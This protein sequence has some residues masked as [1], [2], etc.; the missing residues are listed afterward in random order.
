MNSNRAYITPRF[1]DL[2]DIIACPQNLLP[3]V[4]AENLRLDSIRL[5][6]S[7][8]V[9]SGSD[10]RV[11]R[12]C[13]RLLRRHVHHGEDAGSEL[14]AVLDDEAGGEHGGVEHELH[15]VLRHLAGPGPRLRL[16]CLDDGRVGVDLKHLAALHVLHGLVVAHG[17]RA[18]DALHV[19]APPELG[20]GQDARRV[21]QPVA[22]HHLLNLV[23][24]HL[25]HPVR[26]RLEIRLRGLRLLLFLLGVLAEIQL[27]LADVH[28]RLVVVGLQVGERDLVDGLHQ[29]QHL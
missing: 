2:V 16:Q 8:L 4:V 17:L 20:R 26:Q 18:H 1:E 10:G 27:V 28:Q 29:V 11:R 9:F 14:G 24:E 6:S 12:F 21:A 25:L 15:L 22:H 23:A 3:G 19:G 13:R 5:R 7:R